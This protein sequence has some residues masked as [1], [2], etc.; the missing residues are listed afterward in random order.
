MEIDHL[1]EILKLD[2]PKGEYETLG[3]FILERLGRVPLSREAFRFKGML[4]EIQKA[5]ERSISEVLVTLK[6]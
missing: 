5:D 2:L 3:G 6:E 4:F 1:N